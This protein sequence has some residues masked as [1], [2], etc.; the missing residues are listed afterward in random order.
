MSPRELPEAASIVAVWSAL[1]GPEPRH[2]RGP[3][4]WRGGDGHNVSLDQRRGVWYDHARGEGGGVIDLIDKVQGCDRASSLRWLA[5][6]LGV[7]LDDGRSVSGAER[8][9]YAERRR[10]AEEEAQALADWRDA[11]LR[12]L[13]QRRNHL[14]GT[15]RRACALGVTP[16]DVNWLSRQLD[17]PDN[18]EEFV[19]DVNP[20]TSTPEQMSLD[21]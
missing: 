12:E 16:E 6:H 21:T 10:R 4:F 14:W 3:A 8:Q 11:Y 1:G 20:E 17:P 9:E 7:S 5:S 2:G 15:C 13:T 18:A 19:D